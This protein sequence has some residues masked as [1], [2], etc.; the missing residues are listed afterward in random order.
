MDFFTDLLEQAEDAHIALQFLSVLVV[1]A[2]PFLEAYFTVPIGIIIGFPL[3][4][5]I[6]AAMI[7]NW[8][9]VAAVVLASDKLQQWKEKR[10]AAK[11]SDRDDNKRTQRAQQLFSK[12]GVPGV[13]FIGPLLVGNHIGAFIS[14]VSG[15]DKRH[16]LLWQTI[17]IIVWSVGTGLL[18]FLGMDFIKQ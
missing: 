12:Y 5:T 15:A 18:V 7:G 9:S 1:A 16:V 6:V 8:L 4:M 2:I 14:I 11:S 3:V 13:A 17:S 10:R